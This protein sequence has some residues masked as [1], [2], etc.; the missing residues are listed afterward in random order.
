MR[1]E[2]VTEEISTPPRQPRIWPWLLALLLLVLA[3]L[4]AWWFLVREDDKTTMPRVVGMSEAAARARIADAELEADV[5]R[6]AGAQPAGTV[7]AQTPGAGTQLDTGERVEIAVSTGPVLVVVPDVRGQPEQEAVQAVERARLRAEVRRIF[8]GAEEGSVVDQS[9]GAGGRA[10]TG[11]VVELAVSKGRNVAAVPHVVGLPEERAVA[12]LRSAGFEARI[13]DVPSAEDEGTVVGQAPAEGVEARRGSR[14]RINVSSGE[15]TGETT[16]RPPPP[17]PERS[18]VPTLVGLR[19]APALRRLDAAGY[20]ASVAFVEST[21]PLGTVLAQS[22]APGAQAP[23]GTRVSIRVSAGGRPLSRVPD[24]SGLDEQA[25]TEAIR[26][27][28]FQVLS[29]ER[30]TTDA[31][32]DALVVEQ[33]PPGGRRAPEG[34]VIAIYVGRFGG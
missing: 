22:P 21:R 25:A 26:A 2:V 3:G 24:V 11:S 28:G 30:S 23:R 19:Q 6:R 32:R 15:P 34:G 14:V 29:L 12:T 7:F 13:F 5:D 31:S 27:A 18:G 17:A 9:P 1:E 8:A 20:R 10:R 4:G 16:A 33:Q